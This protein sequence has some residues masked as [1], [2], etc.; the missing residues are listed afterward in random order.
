[1]SIEPLVLFLLIAIGL[2][3]L[4]ARRPAFIETPGGR[5]LVFVT[6]FIVPIASL[7]GGLSTH[8][9]SSKST[10]FCM[11]CHVMEPY[12]Q[13]LLLD[14]EDHLPAAH[15]QNRRVERDHACFVCHTQYTMY[16]DVK[17]KLNGL[18]HLWVYYSGQTPERIELYSPYKNRECLHCH[19]GARRFEDLHSHDKTD[20]VA[21]EI[22]CMDCHGR[23]HDVQ[24]LEGAAMW[25]QG[26]AE[27]LEG[28]PI[29]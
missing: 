18:K 5:F 15:F 23:A 16:G 28:G 8:L 2:V 6:L 9:Q 13:S 21:N 3:L 1:M 11:S 17:A 25:T 26:L 29:E 19:L 20:L 22:S 12:G 24:N 7:R 27:A 10:E 4:I 14:D